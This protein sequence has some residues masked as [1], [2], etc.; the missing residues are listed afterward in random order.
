[1]TTPHAP[2]THGHVLIVED[3]PIKAA[4]LSLVVRGG[5]HTARIV[6]DG[7]SAL[8]TVESEELDLILLDVGL[9]D[10]SGLE[11][12]RRVRMRFGPERLPIIMVTVDDSSET[13]LDALTSGANDYVPKGYDP[14][15]M[16][17]RVQTQ[18]NRKRA[19]EEL[20]AHARRLEAANAQLRDFAHMVSHDLKAP[21]R[22]VTQLAEVL[23]QDL[24]DI[25]GEALETL[26][27]IEERAAA[28]GDMIN[29]VLSYS[30]AARVQVCLE[31]I[32]LTTLVHDT[33]RF[34][35]LDQ[36]FEL[37]IAPLPTVLGDP[38][39][40]RQ[41]FANLFDNAMKHHDCQR[42]H[43]TV[44]V[45]RGRRRHILEIRDDGPGVA[46]AD[47]DRVFQLFRVGGR[48]HAGASGVGL[49]IVRKILERHGG[50][51]RLVPHPG[52]GAWFELRL[53][54]M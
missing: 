25:T 39:Q 14:G 2:Q 27:L 16:L 36:R 28:M 24:P 19:E 47:Q 7:A 11:V 48:R 50:E 53:P 41:V 15:V 18:V 4:V 42:G 44:S 40:L 49:A 54:A 12:L 5:G 6:G 33:A 3:D 8:R 31:P 38:T 9:P 26:Q 29:G 43:L 1:M 51:I 35:G 22:Q 45:R 23:R 34:V 32:D 21:L 13:I 20:R 37:E 17:A 52:R 46:A 10:V 30:R